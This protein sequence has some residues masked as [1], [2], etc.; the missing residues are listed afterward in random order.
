M[1]TTIHQNEC[2]SYVILGPSAVIVIGAESDV[3]LKVRIMNKFLP[4][5]TVFHEKS[6]SLK[7]FFQ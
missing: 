2:K 5:G 3:S 6:H 7:I 1:V 4:S